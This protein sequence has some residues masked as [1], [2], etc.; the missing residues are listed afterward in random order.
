M[1]SSLCLAY[2][3]INYAK[4]DAMLQARAIWA[5]DTYHTVDEDADQD[6]KAEDEKGKEIENQLN[7]LEATIMSEQQDM[8]TELNY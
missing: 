4:P 6:K 7:E 1:V 3:Q 8:Q 2:S 5:T